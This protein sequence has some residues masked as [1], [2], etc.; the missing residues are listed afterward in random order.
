MK[1]IVYGTGLSYGQSLD[2][3]VKQSFSLSKS[4]KSPK[5]DFILHEPEGRV[6]FIL[7]ARAS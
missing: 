3:F 2:W 4:V 6:Y 5:I 1:V 7:N